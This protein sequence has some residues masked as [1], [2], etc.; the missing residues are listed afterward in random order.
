MELAIQ[1]R[2]AW[3]DVLANAQWAE[4]RGLA[5]LAL[6]D[7]YLS[8]L[9]AERPAYD[10]LIHLAALATHTTTLDL[11]SLVSPITFRHPAVL[12]KTAITIDQMA[13]GRF[14]LGVGTGWMDSEHEL[15]GFP[16][17]DMAT[18]YDMLEEALGYLR[19]AL[20]PGAKGYEGSHYRLAEF[21]PRPHPQGVPLVVGGSGKVR[22]P[23]LA[24]RYGDEYNIYGCPSDDFANKVAR[25]REAASEAGRN[26][27][28]LFIT[29]ACPAIAAP[30]KATYL[31]LVAD[32]ASSVDSTPERLQK[33]M[34]KRGYPHGYG[35]KPYEMLAELEA[36]GCRRF[37]MQAFAGN[38]DHLDAIVAAYTG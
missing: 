37:Y 17:P 35:A 33:S 22:T 14:R 6:P 4:K 34:A 32:F 27:D 2:G 18:R 28:H 5:A 1:S 15:F 13:P 9:S 38:P 36:A 19:A 12:Y 11:V 25:A 7:H 21:D 3:E 26:P 23:Y 29:T 30:D 20:H 8:S 24:G 16:Y 10:H 31:E